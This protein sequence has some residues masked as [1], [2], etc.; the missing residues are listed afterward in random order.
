MNA[1]F[2]SDILLLDGRKALSLA[3]FMDKAA[4][5]PNVRTTM[6]GIMRG[7]AMEDLLV[8]LGYYEK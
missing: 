6:R 8:L 5:Y 7:W 1:V 3:F 4:C 2:S